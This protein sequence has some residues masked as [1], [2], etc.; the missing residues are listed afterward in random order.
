MACGLAAGEYSCTF[1]D[2]SQ[3]TEPIYVNQHNTGV[4]HI[5]FTGQCTWYAADRVEQL[6]GVDLATYAGGWGDGG[7]WWQTAQRFGFPVYDAA[8]ALDKRGTLAGYVIS[9]TQAKAGYGTHVAVVEGYDN[10]T[11]SAWVSEMWGSQNW[12]CEVHLTQYTSAELFHSDMH[13]I[14]FSS[15]GMGGSDIPESEI[16]AVYRKVKNGRIYNTL[17]ELPF[18]RETIQKLLDRGLMVG[19]GKGKL[20]LTYDMLRVLV[21]N[22]RAGMYDK[23]A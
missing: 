12:T 16:K 3:L 6:T 18:G 7:E 1:G 22:D 13:Y 9:F 4:D 17:D 5:G 19:E 11:R 8:T 10:A 2:K 23:T 20:G 21:I 14:D 15:I